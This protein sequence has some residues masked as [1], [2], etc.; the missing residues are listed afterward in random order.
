MIYSLEDTI[1]SQS[2]PPGRGG[3]HVIRVS[4]SKS[5]EFVKNIFSSWDLTTQVQS[6][7]VYYGF[8]R[9]PNSDHKI[10]E[11]MVTFF[12]R[13]QS[14]TYEDTVEISCHGNPVIVKLILDSLIQSGC[15]LSERGEFTYRAFKNGR[16]SLQQ[17]EAVLSLIDSNTAS[18]VSKSL[19]LL[20]GDTL[21]SVKS[22]E[23]NLIWIISRLEARIDFSSEDI[24]VDSDDLILEKLSYV[25]DIL[26]NSLINYKKQS[27]LDKGLKTIIVGPP[28]A[29]KSSLFN[30]LLGSNR[31]IV[32]STPGTTR[33]YLSEIINIKGFPFEVIDTAGLRLNPEELETQGIGKVKELIEVA[34]LIIIMLSADDLNSDFL[35]ILDGN[36]T[37][38][39]FIPVI[40]KC[41]L[42][43]GF[44]T[45]KLPESIRTLFSNYLLMSVSEQ[46]G[47]DKLFD[48]MVSYVE[49]FESVESLEIVSL[50]QS[51][52][53]QNCL[54]QVSNSIDVL[55]AG[56]G[57][58]F[59]LSHLNSSLKAFFSL[60]KEDNEEIIRDRIFK[61]FCLGK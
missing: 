58:E 51:E 47:L 22:I 59:V 32:S 27:V 9:K 46:K 11:V 38:K 43:Q 4:G 57:D 31:S 17:A 61:D 41:D 6:H 8:I 33:D 14:F 37:D 1:C 52:A 42:V 30:L 5:L 23:D 12:Q 44:S 18:G 56:L 50:R 16:L 53:F 3:I 7:K 21:L 13:G 20:S 35:S 10:D 19:E 49:F 15:R 45:E 54:E 55:K 24:D 28:N 25:F 40:N 39:N 60:T 2:T 48:A 26:T 29:G 34:D 36:I